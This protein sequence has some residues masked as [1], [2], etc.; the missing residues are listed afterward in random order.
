LAQVA[1]PDEVIDYLPGCCAGCGQDLAGGQPAGM[2]CRQ[3]HDIPE[4][5]PRVSEHLQV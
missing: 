5:R 1:D 2:V 4:I 3:V